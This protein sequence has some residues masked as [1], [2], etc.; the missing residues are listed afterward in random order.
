MYATKDSHGIEKSSILNAIATV[1]YQEQPLVKDMQGMQKKLQPLL[2][3]MH[4]FKHL[5]LMPKL[6]KFYR[7]HRGPQLY[8][9]NII[10]DEISSLTVARFL[11]QVLSTGY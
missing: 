10:P 9:Q 11:E 8:L 7:E 5:K 6:A 4:I 1:Q 3:A 2:Q